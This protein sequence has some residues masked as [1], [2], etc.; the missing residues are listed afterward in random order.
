MTGG[1]RRAARER[2]LSLLYEADIKGS[3]IATLLAELPAQPDEFATELVAGVSEHAEQIDALL[4]AQAEG[5]ALERM[6]MVDR[7]VLRLATYEL[8]NSPQIPLAVVVSEAVELAS[9]FSTDASGRYVNGVL[10]ALARRLR[11]E[12]AASGA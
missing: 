5:W 9:R 7:S 1:L 11:P 10:S 12:E 4:S 6:P 8:L 2:A 3:D